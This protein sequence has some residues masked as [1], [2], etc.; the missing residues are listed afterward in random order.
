MKM[1]ANIWV[2]LLCSTFCLWW[3]QTNKSD[4]NISSFNWGSAVKYYWCL[5]FLLILIN[6]MELSKQNEVTSSGILTKL[7]CNWPLKLPILIIL[8][9]AV[10]VCWCQDQSDNWVRAECCQA[11]WWGR[12]MR[13]FVQPPT[14]RFDS[15][16]HKTPPC[17]TWNS[18]QQKSTVFHD[19][20]FKFQGRGKLSQYSSNWDRLFRNCRPFLQMNI[21][22]FS[23]FGVV[24]SV[25]EMNET[26]KS[27]MSC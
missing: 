12:Q 20:K 17:Q 3:K 18:I 16:Q 25:L 6:C 5:L 7:S 26:K 1:K 13:N 27:K 9:W 4:Q 19:L 23:Q 8:G 22:D 14:Q 2:I 24:N 21:W 10:S 15:V 11:W